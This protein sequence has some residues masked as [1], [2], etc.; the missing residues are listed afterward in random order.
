[1]NPSLWSSTSVVRTVPLTED[2]RVDVLVVGA[3]ITGL[4]A[5]LLL[6]RAGRRVAVVEA[7]RIGSGV[8]GSS[9]AHLTEVLDTRYHV[10][11]N[12][13]GADAARAVAASSRHAIERIASLIE[14]E[15]LEG[16]AFERVPGYLFTERED[17]VDELRTEHAAL[18]RVGADAVLVD[19][20]PLPFPVKAAIEIGSQAQLNPLA[21]VSGLA[22]SCVRH[23]VGIYEDTRVV[24]VEEED[25]GCHV[26]T[27][28]GLEIVADAVFL[29]TDSPLTRFFLQTKIASYRSYV[30]AFPWSESLRGLF[31]DTSDPY[32]YVRTAELDGRR[33]LIVGGADHKT[34]NETE[35][36]S[37]VRELV[38]YARQ[39]FG[40]AEPAMTWSAQVVEPAD[41]LPFI[42]K[43]GRSSRIHVATGFSGNGLTFGT[44]AAEIVVDAILGR[45]NRWA[46]LFHASRVKPVAGFESFVQENLDVGIHAV[47][48]RFRPV[49]DG[50]ESIARGEGKIVRVGGRKLAVFRDDQSRLHALSP[51]CTHLGCQVQ[52]NQTE[53]SWD[54]PCHGA[55]FGVDGEVVHGPAVH[56]L[57]AIAIV[58]GPKE[59]AKARSF[60][61]AI[62]DELE[63]PP[64][65]AT[66]TS[67]S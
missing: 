10:I 48:D 6:A 17:G 42:G 26:H 35:T 39:R 67:G 20:A 50:T 5:A 61:S 4:T 43:A 62:A 45:A 47:T 16:A 21:Y 54:C 38:A 18:L 46:E 28:R 3:G 51:V 56:A 64:P 7:R 53:Q 11:E 23:E 40:T 32:H 25:D 1:M 19:E 36:E 49:D 15:S 29:A 58:E 60:G 22:A 12:D 59:E 55:R 37:H 33:W 65:L 8:T 9:T 13:F 44:V 31:W 52:W 14:E 57:R 34:G 2:L 41:G 63:T 27:E 24:R 30:V 66:A